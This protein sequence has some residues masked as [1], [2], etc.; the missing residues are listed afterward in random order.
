MQL[1]PRG[2]RENQRKRRE[3]GNVADLGVPLVVV[4][5]QGAR[6]IDEGARVD[7]VAAAGFSLGSPRAHGEV[8]AEGTWVNSGMTSLDCRGPGLA[9]ARHPG[10]PYCLWA[11]MDPATIDPMPP[12]TSAIIVRV[13]PD[14]Q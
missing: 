13:L 10:V 2:A 14:T 6:E 8:V 1:S 3:G 11:M 7:A 5:S 12:S 9:S 4:E